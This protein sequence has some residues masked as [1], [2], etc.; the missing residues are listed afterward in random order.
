MLEKFLAQHMA[1]H[2]VAMNI[3]APVLAWMATCADASPRT[4][5]GV[6]RFGGV[7]FQTSRS[8]VE[9]R[10]TPKSAGSHSFGAPYLAA[11]TF[12]QIAILWGWHSPAAFAAATASAVLMALMHLSLFVAALWFW[13]SVFKATRRADWAPL[14]ALL[15]TGKLFCLLGLLL[16]FA[17]RTLYASAAFIQSCFAADGSFDVPPPVA[18]QQLAGLLM[19]TAC[20]LV[21]VTAAIAIASRLLRRVGTEGWTLPARAVE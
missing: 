11:A 5:F 2:I 15:I 6:P 21:Y 8:V 16:A 4:L 17:P 20:P 3:L 10:V 12:F 1:M 19:L 13:V 18:D 14:G 9:E 7:N